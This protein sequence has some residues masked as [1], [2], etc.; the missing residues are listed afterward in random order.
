MS[1][2]LNYTTTITVEKTI[3]E[4]FAML[5]AA[6][7]SAIQSE[8]DGAG[9]ITAIAFKIRTDHGVVPFLLPANIQAA[10]SILSKQAYNRQIPSRFQ[11]DVPQA[12]RVAWRIIRQW[13]E[14]QL[15][16]VSLGMAKME[17]VFLPYAQGPDGKTVFETLKDRHFDG[18]A[19]PENTAA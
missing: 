16:L 17:E 6:R 13:L 9:N 4:I 15:A 19:L 2:L 5:A 1:G 12:R 7:V 3:G 14:A 8:Y 10:C 11:N 18:L